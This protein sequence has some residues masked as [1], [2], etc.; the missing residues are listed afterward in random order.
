MW[1]F[2]LKFSK[3]RSFESEKVMP[4]CSWSVCKI[5][6]KNDNRLGMTTRNR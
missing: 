3:K 2:C 5:V 6:R 4:R 1:N